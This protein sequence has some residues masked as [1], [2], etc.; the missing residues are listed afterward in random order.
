MLQIVMSQRM[1]RRVFDEAWRGQL[2]H[3][4][5]VNSLAKTLI[6]KASEKPPEKR[7]AFGYPKAPLFSGGFSEALIIS[8]LAREFTL[9]SWPN[10]PRQASSKTL[11]T[12]L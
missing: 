10:C 7:G 8:V 9:C 3:E 5:R 4:Q 1:V 12:I 11:L 2:G 6:I